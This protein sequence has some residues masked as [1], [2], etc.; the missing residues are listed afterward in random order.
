MADRTEKPTKRRIEEA[1]KE[2]QVVKSQELNTAAILFAGILLLNGPGKNLFAD[3]KAMLVTTV[4]SLTFNNFKDISLKDLVSQELLILAPVLAVL[5]GGFLIT[6]VFVTCVQTQFLWTSKR[7]KPDLSRLNPLQGLK[8][9]FSW[10]GLLE[11]LKALL[12]LSVVGLTAYLF[13]KSR[14]QSLLILCQMDFHSAI[15]TWVDLALSMVI[16]IG[17]VYLIIAVADYVYQRWKYMRSLRMTKEEIK[18]EYKRTEGDPILKNRIRSQQR[19][20]ARM[21]MMANVPKASVIIT[22]PT[23]LAIAIEYDPDKMTAPK[24]VA[25]G[26]HYVAQKIVSIAKEYKIPIVQNIPLAHS[27]YKQV[28]IDREIPPDLYKAMAEILAYVYRLKGYQQNNLKNRIPVKASR[29][30]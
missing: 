14:Y 3:I 19:S 5:L 1:R 7:L 21:R 8:R 20:I 10:T 9:I 26:A 29:I 25:K 6:G 30:K 22:N 15:S 28:D 18:E 11:L 13:I 16:W 27:L 2:G 23:H 12:K 17:M 4:T 24:V